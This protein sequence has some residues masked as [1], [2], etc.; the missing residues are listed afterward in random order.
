MAVVGGTVLGA[1]SVYYS[2]TTAS[3]STSTGVSIGL[4]VGLTL[5]GITL[6]VGS[7]ITFICCIRRRSQISEI[8]VKDEEDIHEKE[9]EP[10]ALFSENN[11]GEAESNSKIKKEEQI[12]VISKEVSEAFD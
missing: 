11:S 10:H 12:R 3:T 5:A 2:L 9:Q 6:L 4:I 8:Q 1:S 7:F